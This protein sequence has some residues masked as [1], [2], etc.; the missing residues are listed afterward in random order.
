M[1]LDPQISLIGGGR[2]G[3]A[4]SNDFD[5]N[6]YLMHLPGGAWL[7]DAGCGL[8]PDRLLRTA[9]EAAGPDGIEGV[10]ITHAHPDHAGGAAAFGERGVRVLAGPETVRRMAVADPAELGLDLAL[11]AC[12][13]PAGFTVTPAKRMQT[14]TGMLPDDGRTHAAGR[15]E[16]TAHATPGHSADHTAYLLDADRR[17]LFSGDLVFG[18]G[19]VAVLATPDTDLAAMH[20]SLRVLRALEPDVLL[21]GH[22]VPV[23]NDAGWHLDQALAAFELGRL[24]NNL[25]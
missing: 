7:V 8:E 2:L 16:L 22:G 17:Y 24:P 1:R 23:M 4:L 12:I 21:P 19:R 5:A 10:L 3:P 18:R 15:P 9:A 14:V 25:T 6:I 20:R 11:N 13:Y